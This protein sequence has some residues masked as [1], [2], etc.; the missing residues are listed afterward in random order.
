MDPESTGYENILLRGMYLGF[1]RAEIR[2]KVKDVADF[3]GLG[4]FID[5]PAKTYSTGMAA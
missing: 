4:S 1:S 3:A 5:M 2:A